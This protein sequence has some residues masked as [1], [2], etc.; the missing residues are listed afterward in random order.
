VPVV[1]HLLAELPSLATGLVMVQAEVADRLAAGPGSRSYGV[2]SVKM[3]WYA[4]ARRAGSVPRAVFW[5]VPGV[6]S[7]L[8]AFARRPAPSTVSKDV[9]FSLVD[10][11]FAQRRKTLRAALAGW[12]GSADAAQALLET[13][14]L[15]PAARG[16]QLS[17]EDFAR[18]A[19]AAS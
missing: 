17:V 15:S 14:G 19:S 16:E 2:P 1:L 5:P 13:A 7:A 10:A 11:A 8:V 6:D 12:A 3:A 9:L 4:Q 18:L